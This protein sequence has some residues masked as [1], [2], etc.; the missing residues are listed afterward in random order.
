MEVI[1]WWCDGTTVQECGGI[2][3]V[4]QRDGEAARGRKA[5][6]LLMEEAAGAGEAQR[7]EGVT[8]IVRGKTVVELDDRQCLV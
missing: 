6:D 4:R 3:P 5:T 1:L 2:T 8:D 7:N